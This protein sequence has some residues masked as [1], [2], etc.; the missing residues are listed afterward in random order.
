MIEE[1]SANRLILESI[2][3]NN[4]IYFDKLNI[5]LSPTS[6]LQSI[7][8]SICFEQGYSSYLKLSLTHELR[9]GIF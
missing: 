7:K 8:V 2:L 1:E 9:N 4:K 5:I 6:L 3:E